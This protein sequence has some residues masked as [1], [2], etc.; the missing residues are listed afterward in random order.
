MYCVNCLSANLYSH[1]KML[2]KCSSVKACKEND[3]KIIKL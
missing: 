2:L 1:V 3:I